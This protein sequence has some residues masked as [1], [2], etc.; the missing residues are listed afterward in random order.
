MK[1]KVG[2]EKKGVGD[3]RE[4]MLKKILMLCKGERET[5]ALI[6]GDQPPS[7]HLCLF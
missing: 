5:K 7:P 1:E 6:F 3:V 4:G 2:G